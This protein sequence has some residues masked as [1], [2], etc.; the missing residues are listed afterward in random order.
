MDLETLPRMALADDGN[1]MKSS[2]PPSP[3]DWERHKAIIK[4]FY[5]ED[6]MTLQE[7]MEVMRT[8]YNFIAT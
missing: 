4:D 3:A 1:T 7:L 6:S 8:R 5:I 2:Q